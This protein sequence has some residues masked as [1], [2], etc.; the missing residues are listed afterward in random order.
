MTL[1]NSYDARLTN[2]YDARLVPY[3]L[4]SSIVNFQLLNMDPLQFFQDQYG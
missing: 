3:D 1:T 2:S 4:Y